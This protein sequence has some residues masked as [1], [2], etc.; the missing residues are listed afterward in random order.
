MDGAW[1]PMMLTTSFI[2]PS[3]FLLSCYYFYIKSGDCQ[4]EYFDFLFTVW[5][6]RI[7]SSWVINCSS[8]VT[9]YYIE[10]TRENVLFLLS[11]SCSW[12]LRKCFQLFLNHYVGCGLII[13]NIFFSFLTALLMTFLFCISVC[14]FFT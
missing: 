8:L 2:S 1:Y 10:N 11:L 9:Q 12:S 14:Q 6:Y 7:S 4:Q 5:R 13:S 3:R